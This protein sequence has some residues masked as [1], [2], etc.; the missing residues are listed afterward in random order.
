MDTNSQK[1]SLVERAQKQLD[2]SVARLEAALETGA[3]GSHLAQELA[4][5]RSQNA[6]LR[7]VT[8]GVSERLDG[9]IDRI[10]AVLER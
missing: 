2:E 6:A 5:V 3:D 7:E 4:A 1:P 9:A 10:R 8:E